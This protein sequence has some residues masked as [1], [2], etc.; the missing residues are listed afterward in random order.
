MS[1]GARFAV[2]DV[3]RTRESARE[4]HTRLPRYLE[5]RRGHIV[6][7]H[8]AYPLADERARGVPSAPRPLYAVLFDGA[9]VWGHAAEAPT[10]I[11]ADLWEDYLEIP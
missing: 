1:A 7:V 4:G 9:E 2:G 6:A 5:R 10:A 3:V 11:V 8:G